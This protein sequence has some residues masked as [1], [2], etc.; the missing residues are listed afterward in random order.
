MPGAK[1]HAGVDARCNY[2]GIRMADFDNAVPL[3]ANSVFARAG[4]SVPVDELASQFQKRFGHTTPIEMLE[5]TD[6]GDG[7]VINA[8]V[9]GRSIPLDMEPAE[10]E[11]GA[12]KIAESVFKA[13]V[14]PVSGG[15]AR[16]PES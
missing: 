7:Y 11:S 10:S 1:N 2:V 9:R 4:G 5:I 8:L 16:K 15:I 12:V 14:Y 13:G 6:S 3:Y